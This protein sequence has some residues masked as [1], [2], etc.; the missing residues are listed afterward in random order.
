MKTAS[1]PTL[2]P[3]PLIGWKENI[4]LPKL[5]V[6]P[7]LAKVDTGA[8]TAALHADSIRVIGNRVAFTIEEEGKVHSHI[9]R[10]VSE[11]RIK[12]SNGQT[13][14]RPVIE[15]HL[16]IGA[17]SFLTQITLTNR[18]DMGVPMLLGR[19]TIKGRYIVNPARS[20]LQSR[21]V[22]SK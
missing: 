5:N 18:T 6:G 22:K 10:L 9:A 2:F 11:K 20:F 14:T 7:L 4:T 19:E 8:R 16:H 12:S 21:K 17:T 15:T 1:R 3:L 13:E